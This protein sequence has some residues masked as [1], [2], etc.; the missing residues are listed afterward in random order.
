MDWSAQGQPSEQA[1]TWAGTMSNVI[2]NELSAPNTKRSCEIFQAALV[3]MDR[4]AEGLL[5]HFGF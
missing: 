1:V 4:N 2:V 3:L 5:P